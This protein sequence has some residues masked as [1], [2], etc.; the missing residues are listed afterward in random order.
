MLTQ[1]ARSLGAIGALVLI[2]MTVK[3]TFKI[4]R[5]LKVP[6][7]HAVNRFAALYPGGWHGFWTCLLFYMAA[8]R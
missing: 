3:V 2:E 7:D 8:K 5:P 4:C 1:S 6:G